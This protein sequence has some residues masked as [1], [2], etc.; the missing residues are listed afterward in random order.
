M[1]LLKFV[2]IPISDNLVIVLIGSSQLPSSRTSAL[3]LERFTRDVLKESLGGKG[4]H[5]R[6]VFAPTNYS[7]KWRYICKTLINGRKKFKWVW[8]HSRKLTWN[9]KI[10]VWKMIF[11]INLGMIFR[12]QPLVFGGVRVC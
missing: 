9:L 6:W 5:L 11:L 8:L 2:N 3:S 10:E 7:H 1:I 4:D 12:F